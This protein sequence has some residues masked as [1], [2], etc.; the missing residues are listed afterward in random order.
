VAHEQRE[1]DRPAGTVLRLERKRLCASVYT[2]HSLR[3]PLAVVV[4]QEPVDQ[5]TGVV[6]EKCPNCGKKGT[7][8]RDEESGEMVC[9]NC[10][11][12]LREKEEETGPSFSSSEGGAQ[13]ISSGPPTSIAQ[14][15]M[16][17]I[18]SSA[19]REGT[20]RGARLPLELGPR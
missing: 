6:P 18:P 19:G 2:G 9:S 8:L 13:Q 7:F 4:R 20:R 10:G 14:P 12:V 16:V 11:F 17:W 5:D 3:K 15:D 1:Q